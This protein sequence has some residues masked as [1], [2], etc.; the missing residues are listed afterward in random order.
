ML[1]NK[2]FPLPAPPLALPA[3][4]SQDGDT[5]KTAYRLAVNELQLTDF[6]VYPPN[7]A[8]HL[9]YLFCM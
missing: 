3:I 7:N 6:F 4:S 5:T 1:V 9:Y 2:N 8:L